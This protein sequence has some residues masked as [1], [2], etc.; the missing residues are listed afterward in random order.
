MRTLSLSGTSA[1]SFA[2]GLTGPTIHHGVSPPVDADGSDGDAYLQRG[3]A[4]E[5]F[6]RVDGIWAPL[7]ADEQANIVSAYR[8]DVVHMGPDDTILRLFRSPYTVDTIDLTADTTLTVDASPKSEITTVI[9]SVEDAVEGMERTI[10]DV[11]LHANIFDVVFNAL[12]DDTHEP[13]STDA[14]TID[15]IYSGSAWRLV[16]R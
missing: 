1:G 8:G 4:L 16:S 10:Q 13:M 3:N 2:I 6:V 9:I 12:I 7:Y 5:I 14:Q 11:S 15:I